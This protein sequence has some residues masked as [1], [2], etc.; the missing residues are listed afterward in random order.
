MPRACRTRSFTLV[1]MSKPTVALI[2]AHP[3]AERSLA[4]AELLKAIDDLHFID[5]RSLYDLYPDSDIDAD[6]ERKRLAKVDLVVLQHP[7][8]WY[9]MPSLLKQWIDEVFSLGWAYG[10]D[11]RALHGKQMLWVVTTGADERAYAPDGPHGH[12]FEVFTQPMRQTAL[13]CGMEWLEP[14]IVHDA[15]A[16]QNHVAACGARYRERL[17]SYAPKPKAAARSPA[18]ADVAGATP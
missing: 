6:T 5:R 18:I 8:Y 1:A 3:Y 7:V 11:G 2:Y 15:H 12:P 9:S 13:F 4:N 16:D 17:M 14:I 10:Q